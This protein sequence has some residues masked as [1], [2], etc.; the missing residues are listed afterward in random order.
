[1]DTSVPEP[2]GAVVRG[3]KRDYLRRHPRATDVGLMIEVADTSL[4]RDRGVKKRIFARNRIPVYWIINLQE[5]KI[6]VYSEPTGPARRPTYR[7][8]RDYAENEEV[9]LILD[10]EEVARIPVRDLLP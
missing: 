4:R 6:E 8:R 5:R 10:G 1:L 3:K 9:P 2:D 7:Q